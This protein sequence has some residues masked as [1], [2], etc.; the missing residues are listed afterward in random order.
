[1]IGCL[2]NV[3]IRRLCTLHIQFAE[4]VPLGTTAAET[5]SGRT[6]RSPGLIVAVLAF[7]GL[8]VALMQSLVIPIQSELPHLL[9]TS[10][11]NASW[12]LTATLLGGAVSMPVAG[13]LADMLG[14]R[15]VLVA[16]AALLL[17]GS[18]VDA[19]SSSLLPVLAGRILQGIA[20]GYIPVAIS[21]VR[22]VVPPRAINA[23]IATIS[24]TL[25]VGGALGLPLAAWIAQGHDWHLLFWVSAGLA[26]LVTVLAVVALPHVR[27]KHDAK[28]DV[29]GVLGLAIG[30]IA[31]LVGVSK[32]NDWGW[33]SAR[34]LGLIAVGVVVLV[35]WAFY[36]LRH[37][38]PLVDLRTT[39]SRPVLLTNIAALMIGFGLMTQSIVI[40][41]L[42]QM[43]R[44][45]GYGLGQ[46]V[47]AAGLWLA[48]AGVM[49]MLFAP[50]SS[51]LLTRF[52]GRPALTLGAAVL[53]LGYVF[54]AILMHAPWQLML[55]ACIA[56]A[57]VGIGYAAM[58]AIILENVP[59]REAASSVG[60]NS[61]MRSVGTTIAGAVMAVVLTSKT[62]P[63]GPGLPE[64]PTFDAF[65]LCFIVG[66][67]AAAVGAAVAVFVPK[68]ATAT[69]ATAPEATPETVAS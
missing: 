43:P 18:L 10:V 22:E 37:H 33:T 62:V 27:D 25:G 61:L 32:G 47:L 38:D 57:G 8:C 34:T 46:S 36:E 55:A 23:A 65:R 67:I 11:S 17:V 53:S 44:L 68:R 14:K 19:L 41:Q 3:H 30:L 20:L 2:C 6:G 66:A 52:G 49:M 58:P 1:V 63:L 15:P 45:S 16:S 51:F 28:L 31:V 24:A 5:D 42:L 59:D 40:P 4:E 56:S 29:I 13:R 7:S 35:A 64:I 21:F 9:G 50:V 26:T 54:G 60:V 69:V 48:P 12:V 39:A